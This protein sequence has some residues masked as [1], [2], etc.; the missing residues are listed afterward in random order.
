MSL[1]P[2]QNISI[3][4]FLTTSE[5]DQNKSKGNEKKSGK[6]KA[7]NNNMTKEGSLCSKD[8]SKLDSNKINKINK[9]TKKYTC[10]ETG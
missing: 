2:D 3:K 8:G 1:K 4:E 10:R 6:T 5:K 7:K 9:R